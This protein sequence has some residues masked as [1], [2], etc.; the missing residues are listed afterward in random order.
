M[1]KLSECIARFGIF[2]ELVSDNGTQFVAAEVQKFL[3]A[4]GV[5]HSLTSP[6]HPDTNGAAENIVK[7]F[8]SSLLKNSRDQN[9]SICSIISNFVMGYRKATHCLTGMSPAYLMFMTKT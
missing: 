9:I 5:R 7:T 6:G 8:K 1:D 3:S 2:H 4:N